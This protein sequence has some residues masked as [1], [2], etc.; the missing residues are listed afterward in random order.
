MVTVQDRC[1]RKVQIPQINNSQAVKR[2]RG[3]HACY[4][5]VSVDE[6]KVG[7]VGDAYLHKDLNIP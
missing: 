6:E 7:M 2:R 1:K 4:A 3:I 5:L